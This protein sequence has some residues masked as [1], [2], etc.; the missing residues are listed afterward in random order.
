MS[1]A[2]W[3]FFISEGKRNLL[4]Y[5]RRNNARIRVIREK[6]LVISDIENLG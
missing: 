3:T 6:T 1:A 5:N 2:F 4:E